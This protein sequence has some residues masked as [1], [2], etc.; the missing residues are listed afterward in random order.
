M[1]A[2]RSFLL[3]ASL[4]ALTASAGPAA[5]ARPRAAVAAQTGTVVDASRLYALGLGATADL[6][7]SAVARELA[8]G[9]PWAPGAR[10]LVR[11]TGLS[12]NA[13]AGSNGGGGGGGGS[14]GGGSGNG[15]DFDYLE[16]DLQVVGPRGEILSQRHLVASSPASSGGAYYLPNAEGRRLEAVA[17]VFADW[18]RRAA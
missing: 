15:G 16:G 14:G 18:L 9:V 7:R 10:V 12:M 3:I 4:A 6:V 11:L 1:R 13:Y 5:V 8:G 17:R 2:R